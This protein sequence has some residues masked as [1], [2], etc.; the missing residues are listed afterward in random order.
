M[1]VVSRVARRVWSG[2]SDEGCGGGAGDDGKSGGGGRASGMA[3]VLFLR[4]A[5]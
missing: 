4:T 3:A 5:G 1:R 2:R